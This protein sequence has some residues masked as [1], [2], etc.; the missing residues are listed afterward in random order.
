MQRTILWLALLSWGVMLAVGEPVLAA[1][2]HSVSAGQSLYSVCR[3]YYGNPNLWGALARY[4]RIAQPSQ[5]AIG[6]QLSIPTVAELR[7][8]LAPAATPVPAALPVAAPVSRGPVHVACAANMQA[9]LTAIIAD[10][11]ATTGIE[12]KPTFSSTKQLAQ[13]VVAGAP[14][15]LF[16]A[17]DTETVLALDRQGLIQTGSIRTYAY[18]TLVLWLPADAAARPAR[19]ADIVDP[20]YTKIGIANPELAPYGMAAREA[21][22][23][24]GI[25]ERIKARLIIAQNVG[26][27]AMYAERGE[28]DVAFTP[29]S[30]A[31]DRHASYLTIDPALY[32]PLAQSLG[33][34][35]RD[36]GNVS[37]AQAL[38]NYLN[39]RVGRAV[40]Q[41]FGYRLP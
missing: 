22:Q 5:L 19:V 21:C 9:A 35:K 32:V 27:A 14:Y 10:Y 7:A 3:Q 24:L 38:A 37:G 40:L 29:L 41:R 16:I 28:V 11:A 30:N 34:V 18:G 31:I 20:R 26:Q 36:G 23:R 25:W 12:V 4:N 15:D 6:Q 13:Q 2:V 39:S 33:V 17:A 8:T 1:T